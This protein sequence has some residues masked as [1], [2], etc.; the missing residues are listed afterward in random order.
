[1]GITLNQNFLEEI[2]NITKEGYYITQYREPVNIENQIEEIRQSTKTFTT[3]KSLH[4]FADK[5][6]PTEPLSFL[7]VEEG[8]ISQVIDFYLRESKQIPNNVTIINNASG[9]KTNQD[10]LSDMTK[11]EETLTKS[12]LVY[13]SIYD[14]LTEDNFKYGHLNGFYSYNVPIIVDS[15][16]DLSEPVYAD[17]ITVQEV[18]KLSNLVHENF[19]QQRKSE[20]RRRIQTLVEEYIQNVQEKDIRDSVLIIGLYNCGPI[21][22]HP[23]TTSYLFKQMLYFYAPVFAER[24]IRVDFAFNDSYALEIFKDTFLIKCINS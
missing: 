15:H 16:G 22:T 10:W 12:S 18:N 13:A 19:P 14:K 3:H 5:P 24:N 17:I 2:L 8:T 23:V 7:T 9:E 4:T 6:T 20:L 21:G 1:M 11:E